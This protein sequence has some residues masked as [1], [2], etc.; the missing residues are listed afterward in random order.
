MS[1]LEQSPGTGRI[2]EAAVGTDEPVE[3]TAD[4]PD[5]SIPPSWESAPA[6]PRPAAR[7]R[8]ALLLATAAIAGVLAGAVGMAVFVTAAFVSAAEDIGRGMSGGLGGEVGR[9]V[10]QGISRS[11][12]A[13]PGGPVQQFPAVAPGHLGSDPVLDRSAW[14]C[15]GGDLQACDSLWRE[16]PPISGY[17]N[18]AATCGGRVKRERVAT[19]TD[20]R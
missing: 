10:G 2:A 6:A 5:W 3:W 20:L 4:S 17:E 14:S 9:S 11:M 18:Y 16:S 15:F 8:G 7:R 19:C 13:S 1:Q 12:Q